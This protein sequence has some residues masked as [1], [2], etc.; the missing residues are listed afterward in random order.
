MVVTEKLTKKIDVF[1]VDDAGL[2]GSRKTFES[3]GVWPFGFGFGHDGTLIVSEADAGVASSSSASSY[4]LAHESI[5]V[6]DG[7]V[8]TKQTAACWLVLTHD[9]RFAYLADAGSALITGFLVSESGKLT[10]LEA[11]GDTAGTDPHPIDMA[12]SVNDKF[13]YL[14]SNNGGALDEFM[15]SGNG[16]LKPL[17]SITGL[18]TSI[19]GAVS[20]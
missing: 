18:P 5:G 17:E 6:V 2:V 12:V 8:P 11:S 9:G 16:S 15:I 7:S 13:L 10:R 4:H 14:V 3:V 19:S 20:N 1:P